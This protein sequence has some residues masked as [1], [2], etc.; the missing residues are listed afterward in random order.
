MMPEN[1]QLIGAGP[2]APDDPEAPNAAEESIYSR[3]FKLEK[4]RLL[5][6]RNLL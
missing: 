5:K 4:V 1:S 2:L 3:E 6:P